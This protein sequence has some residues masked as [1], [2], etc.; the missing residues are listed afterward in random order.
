M[1]SAINS[2]DGLIEDCLPFTDFECLKLE[3]NNV[4]LNRDTHLS[5][6]PIFRFP[7]LLNNFLFTIWA[8]SWDYALF[9]LHKL[10]LQTHMRSHP[11]GLDIWFLVD[12][13]IGLDV[14]F[15]VRPFHTWCVNS[16]G[17][18]RMRRLAWAFAGR[19]CNKYHNLMSWL[20]CVVL[21]AAVEWDGGFAFWSELI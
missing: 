6:C 2:W 16:E 5:V 10:V 13:S 18:G 9:V 17:S 14:W 4:Q 15:L 1:K 3:Q 11:V 19:L 8:I 12:P 7:F 20:R 21:S